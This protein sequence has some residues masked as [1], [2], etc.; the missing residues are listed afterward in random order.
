MITGVVLALLASVFTASAS[1]TQRFA[2]APDTSDVSF[3]L[4]LIREL[5]RKPIWFLG[6][7]CMIGGFGFQ[8]AA[9][10]V[11]SLGL[12]QPVIATELLLVF[13][14]LA[15]RSP[16]RVQKRDWL[17]AAAMAVG[18]A[19][20]LAIAH[21][22][23]ASNT[24]PSSTGP[25]SMWTV[26]AL[27]TLGVTVL[28]W[29][30]A[31]LPGRHGR[32]HSGARQ[33]ALLAIAAGAA[34]GFVAA[35]IKELS[36][37]ISAGPYAVFT[38]WSPYV[39]L[40]AGAGAFFLLTN[41][42]KAGPLAA[43]QPGLTVVDPLV[44]SILGVFLFKETIRH[45]PLELFGEAISLSILIGGVVLLSRSSLLHGESAE[46]AEPKTKIS[47][48]EQSVVELE[49]E[50]QPTAERIRQLVVGSQLETGTELQRGTELKRGAQ[51]ERSPQL[52]S[53][54]GNWPASATYGP[55]E[56]HPMRTA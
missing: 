13:G 4:Q 48:P 55:A 30:L 49:H 27:G 21:P 45:D 26:A 8:V 41:A 25:F 28:F 11:S 36:A 39:L 52:G 40:I 43:S 10:R 14:F 44:A 51:F 29:T 7:L 42:F 56:D 12:V 18:L 23:G 34:W 33:A 24:A 9:L 22:S 6:I 32:K 50:P 35:V 3:N 19:S 37:H 15:F 46:R 47:M 5:I 53:G 38:N 20:F 17:A 54:S 16:G 31:Q 2:A 1:I